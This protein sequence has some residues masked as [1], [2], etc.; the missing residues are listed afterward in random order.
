MSFPTTRQVRWLIKPAWFLACLT[1]FT[2]LT[3][4]VFELAGLS[5]GADPI[6]ET[7]H[8]I[9]IWA[10][11][12][13]LITLALTPIRLLTAQAW[14]IQ[15]RRMTGLFVLFY[16]S[17]HFLNYLVPDQGLDWGAIVE[18][19]VERPFI[20]LGTAALTCLIMLGITSTNGWRR[21]LGRRWQKLHRLVYVVGILACTHFWWQVKLDTLEPTVYAGI[22]AVLLGSRIVSYK[23]S[24]G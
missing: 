19:I 21:R 1:P 9:G 12:L 6:E 16:V 18:D 11:R 2:W 3:L 22:L 8:F 5:L 15:L 4:A 20:T 10:L 24:K 13:L 23:R 14:V 17:V 7:Q